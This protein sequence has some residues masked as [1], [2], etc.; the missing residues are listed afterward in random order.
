MKQVR[1]LTVPLTVNKQTENFVYK[2]MLTV[3]M[4]TPSD[5][6]RGAGIDEVRK[7]IR[8]LDVLE[9]S[10]DVLELEDADFAYVLERV[11]NARF[12][13]SNKVFVDFVEHFEK[14]AKDA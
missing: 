2:D 1:L 7:S 3:L 6:Q 11:R 8:V 9:R 13:A 10:G 12:T 14:A 4:E 5:P